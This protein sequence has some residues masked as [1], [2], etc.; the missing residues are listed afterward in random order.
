MT[1]EEGIDHYVEL[2]NLTTQTQ[3]KST[4]KPQTQTTLNLSNLCMRMMKG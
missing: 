2:I 3:P 1:Q 4:L